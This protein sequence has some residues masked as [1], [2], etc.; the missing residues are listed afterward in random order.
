MDDIVSSPASPNIRKRPADDEPSPSKKPLN[1]KGNQ[2][3]MPTPPDTD[4]SSNTS[5]ENDATRAP[6]PAP[7]S[8]ALSSIQDVDSVPETSTNTA[9]GHAKPT[10]TGQPSAK[11]RK[12]TPSEKI[13]QQR[14]KEAK[15]VEK[16]E[17]KVRRDEEKR[18]R[19]E[20]KRLKAEERESKKR[21]K[22][23]EE[24]R[25]NQDKLKKERSQMRLGAFFQKP[26]TPAKATTANDDSEDSA[27]RARRRSLSLETYDDIADHIR[28]SASPSKGA[29]GTP[30][31][32]HSTPM[33][34][35]QTPAKPVLSDYR[36]YFLP[37][38]LQSHTVLADI[39]HAQRPIEESEKAQTA[40]DSDIND[41]TI[42]EKY[43]LGLVP[44]YACIENMFPAQKRADYNFQLPTARQIVEQIHGTSSQRPIDL[45][46]DASLDDP[47]DMLQS[48]PLRYL[49]FEKDVRP[50]YFGT[51]T[52]QR[53]LHSSRRLSRNPFARERDDTDYDYDSEAEWEE[54]E[55]G[56]DLMNDE[57]DEAESN[58]DPDEM[59]EFLDDE[60]DEMKNKRK[61]ITGDLLP[62][63]TGICWEDDKRKIVL[64]TERDEN[65]SDFA[66]M[67]MSIL[68]PG[69]SGKTIDP[70]STAYWE[71]A[72]MPPP[73]I[74]VKDTFGLSQSQRQPLKERHISNS[75]TPDLIGA[76]EGQKGPINSV[77]ATQG[78]KRGRKPAPKVLSK[79]DLDEFKDAVVGSA[80][81]KADLCKGLKSR[82]PKIPN[83][84]IKDTLGSHFAQ[85]G[86][87]RDDKKWVYVGSS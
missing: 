9:D 44:T 29:K 82:F 75:A 24:E 17:Q 43:D 73:G 71:P 79:E 39:P 46:R 18:A 74:P 47:L 32:I 49:H 76:A 3:V 54:P 51:Y 62:V 22:E 20:E 34:A 8:S 40:F 14:A 19:D 13:E 52:R 67:R 83:D 33:P 30:K 72:I 61:V 68:I 48:L 36:K 27:A 77:A 64:S 37:F 84:V 50:P 16:A 1:L 60:H 78:E 7:S 87:K 63:S 23:L 26:A 10:S 66:D 69:F 35:R 59:D 5:P 57:D 6:S 28:R 4:N 56:E 65:A 42:Q 58:G 85:V 38:D 15:A 81:K 25:K 45:T 31:A 11:R 12:L 55:E 70:F 41:P 80:L 86:S 21:E 2:F 53:S